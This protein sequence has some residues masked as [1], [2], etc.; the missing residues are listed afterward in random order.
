MWKHQN[1]ADTHTEKIKAEFYS[2][3]FENNLQGEGDIIQNTSYIFFQFNLIILILLNG[4][5]VNVNPRIR[6]WFK[7]LKFFTCKREKNTIISLSYCKK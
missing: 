7:Q 1:S 4:N 6:I 2:Y 3:G 5:R